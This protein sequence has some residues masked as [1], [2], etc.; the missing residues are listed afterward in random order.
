MIMKFVVTGTVEN[1]A[2]TSRSARWWSSEASE[3]KRAKSSCWVG[4]GT[5]GVIRGG[6]ISSNVV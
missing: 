3:E 5:A 1:R 6:S 4:L 2:R